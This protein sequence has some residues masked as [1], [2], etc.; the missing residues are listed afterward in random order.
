MD[1]IQ[2]LGLGFVLSF[3]IGCAGYRREALTRSGWL[4]A[5][6]VG[7]SILGFS[8]LEGGLLLIAFFISS[9]LLT[10][11]KEYAKREVAENFAKGGPRDLMQALA[12]G[13]SAALAAILSAFSAPQYVAPLFAALIGALATANA[14]TWATELGVLSKHAPRLIINARIVA[15]GTSG[16]VTWLGTLAALSGA[17]LIATL[18]ALF[19]NDVRLLP[20]GLV[21]GLAG[22]LFDSLLGATLQ[23]LYYSE[24]REKETEKPVE[25]DGA[26]NRH[27]RGWTWMTNDV[28]NLLATLAGA[29]VAYGLAAGW[30]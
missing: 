22:S 19:R 16:G 24:T 9:S 3:L 17:G 12:N 5:V 30:R 21:A 27:L 29:L 20:I 14:D 28:V 8:G 26:R 6:L 25:R 18:A 15:P 11:Y 7:A 10:R 13:G 1:L 4:G 23:G 2:R